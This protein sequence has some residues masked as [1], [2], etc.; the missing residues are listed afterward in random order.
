MTLRSRALRVLERNRRGTYTVPAL[1]LYP[2]QWCWDT[3]P[4]AL[5]WAAAGRWDQAW[6]ELASLCSAQWS[7]GFMPH[8]VFWQECDDYFPGPEVWGAHRRDGSSPATTGVTQ[9]PLPVSVAAMLAQSD[10]DR[11][12]ARAQCAQL[13]PR[14]V[15]WLEWIARARRG[16]HGAAVIVHPWESGMDNSPSWDDPLARTPQSSHR[17][18]DRRDVRTVSATQRPTSAEYRHYLGI[19]GALREAGWDTERQTEDSPF[20][21]E[22]PG[23]TAI[24]VRAAADLASIAPMIGEEGA[25]IDALAAAWRA[26]LEALWDDELGWY[27]AYDVRARRPVGPRTAAGLLAGWADADLVRQDA[28]T[29]QVRVWAAN[30]D[31]GLAVDV[32]TTDPGAA[33]YDPVRYWRGP[34]WVLVNWMVAD[35]HARAGRPE[36]GAALQTLTRSL[37]ERAGFCEYFDPRDGTGI[38]GQGFSW[39]AALTLAWLAPPDD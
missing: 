33:A 28:M 31:F 1:G 20:V 4:I 14:L 10:P 12:R 18:L 8:I 3:G 25:H 36:R 13:W 11:V 15:A 21:V 37:V 34:V 5:G 2:Y 26:G 16:P 19:V 6:S 22:E 23:F 30:P 9:P 7:N 39:S 35:G 32:P 17:H 27:R 38:G 24:A 29:E